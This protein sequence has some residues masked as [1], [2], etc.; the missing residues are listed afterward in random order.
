MKKPGFFKKSLNL[1]K[2]WK[3][4]NNPRPNLIKQVLKGGSKIENFGEIVATATI[5][6]YLVNTNLR[7]ISSDGASLLDFFKICEFQNPR[8]IDFNH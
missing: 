6:D 5:A 3:S 4:L 2:L 1:E 7:T 8:F